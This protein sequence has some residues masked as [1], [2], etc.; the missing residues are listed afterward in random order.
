MLAMCVMTVSNRD[1]VVV[2]LIK[3]NI[4]FSVKESFNIDVSGSVICLS[5]NKL[6]VAVEN[7]IYSAKF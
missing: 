6:V 1:V 7:K 4:V 3:R 5:E 2:D